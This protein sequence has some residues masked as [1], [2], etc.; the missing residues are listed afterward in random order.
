MRGSKE[1]GGVALA[2]SFGP[3]TRKTI[4]ITD[5]L[6]LRSILRGS[7]FSL[8]SFHNVGRASCHGKIRVDVP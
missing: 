2:Q 8:P 5:P 4:I 6:P 1:F 7:K 3:S